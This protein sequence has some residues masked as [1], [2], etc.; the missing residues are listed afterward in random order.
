MRKLY[1][2]TFYDPFTMGNKTFAYR[3]RDREQ[4]NEQAEKDHPGLERRMTRL[5]PAGDQ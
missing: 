1:R 4:A 5:A 2:V 3:A